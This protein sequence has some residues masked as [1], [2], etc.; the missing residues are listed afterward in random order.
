MAGCDLTIATGGPPMVRAAYGS[1]KPAYGVGAGN[2][3]M[4]IDETADV[5]EAA[6]NTAISKTND[7]G[8]GC[9]ADGNLVVDAVDLRRAAGATAGRRRLRRQRAGKGPAS[10]RPTGTSRAAARRTPSRGR[11]TSWPRRPGIAL[12]AGKTF[13][14]VPETNIGKAHLFSTEKLGIV[15]A[16]FKYSGFDDGARDGHGGSSRPAAAAIRAASTRSTTST[17]T[18]WRSSRR[19]AASW[20]GRSSRARMPARSRTA[21][22]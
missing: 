16:V 6:R 14:I 9:S 8:S 11:R 15:L 12:P 2:A 22:R 5:A 1:G 20:C 7:H 10:R 3:T 17:S 21:C 19:S 4:V 13:L 18:A